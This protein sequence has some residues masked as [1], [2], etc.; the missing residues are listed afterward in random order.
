MYVLRTPAAEQKPEGDS[1]WC[2][3]LWLRGMR[4]E[5]DGHVTGR[6]LKYPTLLGRLRYAIALSTRSQLKV[7][8]GLERKR[9]AQRRVAAKAR[10][11]T[12]DSSAHVLRRT[13]YRLVGRAGLEPATKGL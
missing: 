1:C 2:L 13:L 10:P 9:P 5:A 6:C 8:A 3:G 7:S 11:D 12:R 4:I